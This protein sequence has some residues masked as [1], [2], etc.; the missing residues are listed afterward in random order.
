V[1]GDITMIES[2]HIARYLV[3]V[4]DPADRFG[5]RSEGVADLNRLAV[6]N[7]IMA[8]EVVII[9]AKRGGLVDVEGVTYLRKLLEAIDSGL[10][11]LDA[12]VDPDA[13]AFDYRDITLVC[14]WQHLAHYGLRPMDAYPRIA[15]RVARFAGRPSVESTA[16]QSQGIGQTLKS[17]K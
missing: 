10:R 5:V 17:S 9:L 15:A 8:N 4:F 2:D 6:T 7:G 14:M 12:A 13:A 1:H 3:G 16:P 11:W